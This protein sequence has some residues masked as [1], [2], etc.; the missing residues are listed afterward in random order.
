MVEISERHTRQRYLAALLRRLQLHTLASHVERR[1]L[2][3]RGGGGGWQR[4]QQLGDEVRR[5]CGGRAAQVHIG[6]QRVCT[7]HMA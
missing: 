5:R 2:S 3:L 6:S 1:R 4:V 7:D